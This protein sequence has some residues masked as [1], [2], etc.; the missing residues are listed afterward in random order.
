MLIALIDDGLDTSVCPNIKVRYDLTVGT[1]GV[2]R[3]RDDSDRI[4]TDHGTTCARVIAKYAP[5]AEFCSLRIFH[6]EKLRASS[7]QLVAAMEWCLAEQIP[8]V[9]MSLG[10]RQ[11]S[12][13]KKV[14]SIAAKMIQQRQIIVAA[15][16]NSSA[17]SVPAR[18]N[19]VLG[20]IADKGLKE[21]E[22]SA[23]PDS[24]SV[25]NLLCASSRHQL[26]P[27][28]GYALTTQITN[29]YAAPT[30][31]AAVHNILEERGAFSMSAL[32]IY[33]ELIRDGDVIF[34]RPDFIEDAV[35]LNP[36]SIP[37]LRQHL[38]FNCLKEYPGPIKQFSTR[39]E[40]I[41][42]LAPQ[43]DSGSASGFLEKAD[44]YRSLLYGGSLPE[45]YKDILY[46]GLVWSEDCC[47]YLDCIPDHPKDD[48]PAVI[49]LYGHGLKAI[50]VLCQ[51]RDLFIADG[52]YCRGLCDYPYSYLYDLEFLPSGV[53]PEAAFWSICQMYQ[54]DV[55]ISNLQ[56]PVNELAI[57]QD[58]FSILLGDED[59]AGLPSENRCSIASAHDK[60]DILFLY[61]KILN[62]FLVD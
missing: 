34:S 2:I 12:D 49:N 35:I 33:T 22:Y 19:G 44:A 1:D 59:A 10:T 29:S 15:C 25:Y 11:S 9:H 45:S 46:N 61:N 53:M 5:N 47:K 21:D 4:L 51:L 57:E 3:N 23:A 24:A 38:F 58:V 56:V 54:P 31:T 50:D 43:S 30:V 18:L 8:I 27:P 40:S 17:F 55:I 14:R 6:E 52:Y 16:S 20:V 28:S 7:D 37:L 48:H 36:G 41:V 13:Y 60:H 62:Y 39:D 26:A 42:Y 32:Q